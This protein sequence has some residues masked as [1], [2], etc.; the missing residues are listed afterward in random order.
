MAL[1]SAS[2]EEMR[3]ALVRARASGT[4]SVTYSDGRRVEYKTDAEMS[5]AIADL[6]ARL[7]LASGASASTIRFSSSKG[8]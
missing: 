6:D 5:A 1:T 4:R 3:D 7:R 8:F 2:L